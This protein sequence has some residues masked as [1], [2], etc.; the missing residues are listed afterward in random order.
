MYPNMYPPQFIGP[1]YTE[2]TYESD[3]SYAKNY[4][5]FYFICR[6][7]YP[8][9]TVDDG[10]RFNVA[11]TFDGK[12]GPHKITNSSALDVVFTP[13]QL[14]GNVGKLVSIEQESIY[15]LLTFCN[16]LMHYLISL[17]I[18]NYEILL[19]GRLSKL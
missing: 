6:I 2:S 9:Q 14:K 5:D 13:M 1:I 17:R 19:S 7:Q 11:L 15:N 16:F 10:A 18:S 12:P 4:I 3:S 8:P